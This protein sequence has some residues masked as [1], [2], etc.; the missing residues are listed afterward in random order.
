MTP[1]HAGHAGHDD[2]QIYHSEPAKSYDL[3]G[4]VSVTTDADTPKEKVHKLLKE[5][6]AHRGA[7]AVIITKKVVDER[8]NTKTTKGNAISWNTKQHD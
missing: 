4:E 8:N 1:R 7:D 2:V 6:A 3:I 5:K